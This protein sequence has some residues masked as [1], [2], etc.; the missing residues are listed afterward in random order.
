MFVYPYLHIFRFCHFSDIEPG[1]DEKGA[2]R[3]LE[4]SVAPATPAGCV[5]VFTVAHN[6]F[7]GLECT[8][9]TCFDVIIVTKEMPHFAAI[10][11]KNVLKAVNCPTPIVLLVEEHDPITEHDIHQLGYFSLLKKPFCMDALCWLLQRVITRHMSSSPPPAQ[12]GGSS[13]SDDANAGGAGGSYTSTY[14]NNN[15]NPPPSQ[16][17]LQPYD[18]SQSQST[19]ADQQLVP[20]PPFGPQNMEISGLVYTTLPLQQVKHPNVT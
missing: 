3:I 17:Q 2:A 9:L 16:L 4:Q 5:C 12:F 18:S 15:P 11:F 14:S 1:V 8:E 20:Y 7:I 6:A 13:S 10:D 19:H